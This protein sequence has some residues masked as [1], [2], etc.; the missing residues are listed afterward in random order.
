M[1]MRNPLFGNT[2]SGALPS[3][4][5]SWNVTVLQLDDTR[6]LYNVF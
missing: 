6:N 1:S 3:F 4:L 5:G 2:E